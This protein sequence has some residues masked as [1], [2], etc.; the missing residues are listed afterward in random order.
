MA[1]DGVTTTKVIGSGGVG[2]DFGVGNVAQ[3]TKVRFFM[4]QMTDKQA[5]CVGHI[6]FQ[7]S[8]DGTTWTD[9][10]SGDKFMRKGWNSYNLTSPQSSQFF[11]MF[12]DDYI[13]CP[14]T[15][16]EMIGN[17]VIDETATTKLCDV[18]I[19]TNGGSTHTFTAAINYNDGA[20]SKVTD[21]TQDMEP[22]REEKPLQFQEVD[23][24]L[25]M[26]RLLLRLME[27][28]V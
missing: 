21:I 15:E 5:I 24:L 4:G 20:T 7:S 2:Y 12:N 23:F 28:P 25:S 10:F 27:L 13:N 3:L 9:I 16:L 19:T 14:L 18:V 1:F 6:R 8:N 11:R 17:V 22:T 26:L